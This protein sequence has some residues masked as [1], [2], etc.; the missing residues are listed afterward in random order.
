MNIDSCDH[1]KERITLS[2]MYPHIMQM[3]V[4]EYPVVD[5]FGSSTII[6]VFF[7]LFR[8]PGNR[9]VESDIPGRFGVDTPS[10]RGIGAAFAGRTFFLFAAG[11]RTTP[12]ASAASGTESPVDHAESGLTDGCTIGINA[13][14]AGN[15]LWSS[16]IGIEVNK[17][18]DI[19]GFAEVIGRIVI[20]CRVETEVFDA[21]VGV[22]GTELP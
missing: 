20:M 1:C 5:P 19:P 9:C 12:F 16:T 18:A 22:Q 15:C 21:D 8:T 3:V 11:C 17:R 2:G 6:I 7:V 4:I 14:M 10:V 13:D